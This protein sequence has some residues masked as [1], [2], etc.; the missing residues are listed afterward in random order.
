MKVSQCFKT[1]GE[2]QHVC[3]C[4]LRWYFSDQRN[5][6]KREGTQQRTE[7]MEGIENTVLGDMRNE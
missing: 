1:V 3:V 7:M 4:A 6:G 2:G 5:S